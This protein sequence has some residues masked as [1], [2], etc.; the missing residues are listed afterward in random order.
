MKST[1]LTG[2]P[3]LS[4]L[5]CLASVTTLS[6]CDGR[7]DSPSRAETLEATKKMFATCEQ[8]V[9][10]RQQQEGEHISHAE[11]SAIT[12]CVDEMGAAYIAGVKAGR[13]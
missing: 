3:S 2:L 13:Q 1:T 11:S 9:L 12:S 10:G 7:S 4:L 5:I 8:R 6:G